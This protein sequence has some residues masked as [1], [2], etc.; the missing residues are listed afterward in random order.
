MTSKPQQSHQLASSAVTAV[1]PLSHLCGSSGV[2]GGFKIPVVSVVS[3]ATE[4]TSRTV[5]VM[6]PQS[7][8]WIGSIHG[9]DWI[10]LDWIGLGQDF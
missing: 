3:A 2:L 6:T 10:G 5:S 9:L 7:W 8:T 4:Q 1:I